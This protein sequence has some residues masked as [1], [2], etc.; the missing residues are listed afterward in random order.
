MV[1]RWMRLGNPDTDVK[2]A[3]PLW[4]ENS[5]EWQEIDS[6]LPKNHLAR[7]IDQAV[8]QMDLSDLFASYQGR[9][10]RPMRPDLVLKMIL[11]EIETGKPSPAEWFHD[12]RD[13][14]TLK[15]LGFGI[16]PARATF[17]DFR[18]RLAP[19]WDA[20]NEQILAQVIERGDTE[21]K[22]AAQDGTMIAAC[23]S[24]YTMVK[25][26]TLEKRLGELD[27]V[28]AADAAGNSPRETPCWMANHSETREQQRARYEQARERMQQL[29]AENQQRRCS[30]RQ[31]PE[32]IVVSLGDPEAACGRDK[33][34]VFRPL[35]NAQFI[36]D[37]HSPFILSYDVFNRATDSGTME[38]MLERMTVLTGHKPETLLADA[39]YAAV[40]DLEICEQN[41]IR[42]YAP[43]GENDYTKKNKKKP[44]TNQF[45]QLPKTEFRW[46]EAENTY[47][48]P[49]GHLLE[50]VRQ[51]R[52]PRSCGESVRSSIFRCAAQHC[53]PCPRRQECTPNPET[54]RTVS[55]LEN[56]E[57]IEE[58]R[59]RMQTAEAK[60]FYR[61]RAQTIE[62][63]FADMKQHRSMR[64]LTGRGLKRAKA[65]VAAFVLTRNLLILFRKASGCESASTPTRILEKMP[66]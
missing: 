22:Q 48:C 43:V 33:F 55:R 36:V 28:M 4:D 66:A 21:A 62:L 23:A 19:Y 13:S 2:F 5:P 25:Q 10:T 57:L 14:D 18:D 47:R 58:L 53:R 44:S 30:K 40:S 41:S 9:G 65:Q 17:Y 1:S 60:A 29:Q 50:F 24:R 39:T 20:W 46:L 61:L 64:R 11:Y 45:T 12:S 51:Q 35:Y 6:R 3:R 42:L 31:E 38:P 49:E 34:K 59:E 54:G 15:W 63:V 16:Q 27:A 8:D 56:E 32:K 52:V 7:E 26:R 37:L